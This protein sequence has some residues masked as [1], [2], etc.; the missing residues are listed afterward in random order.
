MKELGSC[1]KNL[2]RVVVLHSQF[3]SSRTSPRSWASPRA[4]STQLLQ[5][6]SVRLQ[7][8][9]ER[10]TAGAARGDPARSAATRARE[11]TA[12]VADARRSAECR[13]STRAPAKAILAWRRAALAIDDYRHERRDPH[14]RSPSSRERPSLSI[15]PCSEAGADI[16]RLALIAGE[17]DATVKPLSAHRLRRSQPGDRHAPTITIVWVW[18]QHPAA[19]ARVTATPVSGCAPLRLRRLASRRS[20]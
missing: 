10:R 8:S 1:P 14:R 9:A 17:D 16:R 2:R 7:E 12:G 4:A 3:D 13:P 5:R 6:V 20:A 19:C 18:S 11:R 15:P